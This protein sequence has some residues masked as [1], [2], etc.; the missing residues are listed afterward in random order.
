MS[1]PNETLDVPSPGQM[2]P[3]SAFFLPP[4]SSDLLNRLQSFLPKLKLANEQLAAQEPPAEGSEEVVV[5]EE[6]SDSDSD[7]D[8]D[9]SSE[10]DSSEEEE[11]EESEDDA[12]PLDR[13]R[14]IAAR[15][16]I[17][18]RRLAGKPGVL[19]GGV[20]IVEVED[21]VGEAKMEE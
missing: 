14:D 13:L 8:S 19:V 1:K 21:K 18:R 9:S 16:I 10:D 15:P 2:P 3:S 6:V 7:N 11:E 17:T 20:G 12:A 5:L 4:S